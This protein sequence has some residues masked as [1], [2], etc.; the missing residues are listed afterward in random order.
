MF[1]KLQAIRG[2]NERGV[3]RVVLPD[4]VARPYIADTVILLWTR[5]YLRPIKLR[6]IAEE[7][8]KQHQTSVPHLDE[9]GQVAFPTPM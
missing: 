5:G 3:A 1:R 7:F 9:E 8:R 6:Q 2:A 4:D